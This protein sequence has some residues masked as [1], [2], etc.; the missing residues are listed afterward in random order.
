MGTHVE[1]KYL[2]TVL[3]CFFEF[4]AT[5]T[6]AY[7][8]NVTLP[9]CVFSSCFEFQPHDLRP[10]SD[11]IYPR[12]WADAMLEVALL[13]QCEGDVRSDSSEMEVLDADGHRNTGTGLC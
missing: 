12:V 4:V 9:Q 6:A 5:E 1:H 11:F 13:D 10:L 8:E 3:A 7:L 2:S